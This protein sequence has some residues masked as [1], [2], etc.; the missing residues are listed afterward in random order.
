MV[1]SLSVILGFWFLSDAQAPRGL[2]PRRGASAPRGLS[3]MRRGAG[4]CGRHV[5]ASRIK[6][7]AA[8]LKG[9]GPRGL[10]SEGEFWVLRLGNRVLMS[11]IIMATL[12]SV[13]RCPR[14]LIMDLNPVSP[15]LTR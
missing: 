13:E 1:K 14:H 7:G 2:S 3:L 6:A 10:Y 5:A 15:V 9:H 4:V 12:I 11:G 8:G